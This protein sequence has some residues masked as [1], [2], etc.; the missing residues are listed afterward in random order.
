M[1]VKVVK[2]KKKYSNGSI[3]ISGPSAV[4]KNTISKHLAEKY[5]VPFY[6]LDELICQST[7]FNTTKEIIDT[8]GHAKFK[9]IQHQELINLLTK[10]FNKYFVAC[11]GEILREGYDRNT[12]L[13]NRKLINKYTYNICII[14]SDD[15]DEIIRILY[16]RLDDGKSFLDGHDSVFPQPPGS[17]M[18]PERTPGAFRWSGAL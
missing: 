18:P 5:H 1:N 8:L 15:I 2:V 16:P 13:S 17:C 12:I 3:T 11:G 6:D 4:G 10:N 9:E 14:P 7:K